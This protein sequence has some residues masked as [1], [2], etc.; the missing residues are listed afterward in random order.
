MGHI[1]EFS[2]STYVNGSSDVG[3]RD[4]SYD[5]PSAHQFGLRDRG[6]LAVGN[7]PTSVC[8]MPLTRDG[9]ISSSPRPAVG[10]PLRLR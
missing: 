2:A 5:R 10:M 6:E 3:E 8:L 4:L 7:M 9:E 1:R